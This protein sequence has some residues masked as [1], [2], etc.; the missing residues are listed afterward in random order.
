MQGVLGDVKGTWVNAFLRFLH[1]QKRFNYH[2][3]GLGRHGRRCFC[4][5]T[6]I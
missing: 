3:I 6:R 5:G 1:I 2:K 4:L